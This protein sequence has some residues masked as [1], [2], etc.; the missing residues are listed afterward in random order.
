[1]SSSLEAV[2][3]LDAIGRDS[4]RACHHKENFQQSLFGG[5]VLAQALMASGRTVS[6]LEPHSMHAY[7]L[8]PGSSESPIDYSVTRTRDGRS[9]SHRSVLAVQNG[10]P[11]FSAMMSFHRFELGFEHAVTWTEQPGLPTDI[12]IQSPAE[13]APNQPESSAEPFQFHALSNAMFLEESSAETGS[14][15]WLKFKEKLADEVLLQTCALAYA[16]DLGLLA[17]SLTRHPASLFSGRITGAS[18]DHAIW[19]HHTKFSLNN[20][21]FYEIESPWAGNARGFSQGRI[22]DQQGVLLATTSQEGLI[23]KAAK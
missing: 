6:G 2:L 10:K 4:F 20:W 7:F 5:Q 23:R 3:H 22:F 11:I 13:L 17:S 19:F 9:F 16:S 8:R 12:P 18:I 15:F 21:I 1:M 14:R